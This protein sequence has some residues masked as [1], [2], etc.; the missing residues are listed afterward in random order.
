MALR[1]VFALL[2]SMPLAWSSSQSAS[3]GVL[4][5]STYQRDEFTPSAVTTDA[6]GNVYIAGSVIVD[7][8]A[9]QLA[10]M[11][12]KLNP[13]G[14][15]VIY[16]RTLGGSLNDTGTAVAV[17]SAG[18]A[19]VTGMANSP[20]FPV[21]PGRTLATPP[22]GPDASGAK[23]ARTFLV[24]LDPQG[25]IVF[26]DFLGASIYNFGQAVAVT[27]QGEI[28]VSGTANSGFPVTA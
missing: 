14:T 19:Y 8:S 15:K 10:A 3:A 4:V 16:A 23:D 7:S 26:S 12:M 27:A 22:S 20:D 1:G 2:L 24:K 25:S 11:V 21:T 28:L 17:D 13:A 9:G 6:G 18:N 5:Y